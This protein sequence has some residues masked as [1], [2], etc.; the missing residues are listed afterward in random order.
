MMV[1]IMKLLAGN[2]GS[3]QSGQ[4]TGGQ[5]TVSRCDLSPSLW[6]LVLVTRS[7]CHPVSCVMQLFLL[8]GTR[9][10]FCVFMYSNSTLGVYVRKMV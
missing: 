5:G 2:R 1:I 3:G 8:R 7:I 9:K 10:Y 4:W 6:F